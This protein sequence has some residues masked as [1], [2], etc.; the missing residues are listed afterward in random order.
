VIQRNMASPALISETAQWKDLKVQNSFQVSF[1]LT[2]VLLESTY[3]QLC[4]RGH[5]F[6][7]SATCQWNPDN[8]FAGFDEWCRP[9]QVNDGVCVYCA[10][11]LE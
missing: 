2:E 1:Q 7:S 10:R 8:P 4:S 6:L 11:L 5:L 9:V 3:M